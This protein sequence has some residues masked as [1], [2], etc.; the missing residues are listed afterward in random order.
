M[1]IRASLAILGAVV[2]ATAM[3][4][5]SPRQPIAQ[6][7]APNST[8]LAQLPGSDA[9]PEG[10]DIQKEFEKKLHEVNP[11]PISKVPPQAIAAALTKD[12][13][14]LPIEPEFS[15]SHIG[16]VEPVS[17]LDAQTGAIGDFVVNFGSKTP[18]LVSS[19]TYRVFRDYASAQLIYNELSI[20]KGPE[21]SPVF[22][23]TVTLKDSKMGCKE[24]KC[25]SFLDRPLDEHGNTLTTRCAG[26]HSDAPVV[27]AGLRKTGVPGGVHYEVNPTDDQNDAIEIVFAGMQ[28]ISIE[29]ALLDA[30]AASH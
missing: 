5:V 17:F 6:K 21:G 29:Y 4:A 24:V 19:L 30:K 13:G 8:I 23:K 26:L 2:G 3:S 27:V 25:E 18:A 1:T 14:L 11:E 22:S 16:M 15:T 9:S 10:W 20:S 12:P 28:R 7:S